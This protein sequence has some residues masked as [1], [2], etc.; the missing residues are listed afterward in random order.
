MKTTTSIPHKDAYITREVKGYI[1][2]TLITSG[3][4]FFIF[5]MIYL[6][7]KQQKHLKE[8]YD[9]MMRK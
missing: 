9:R 3:L 5:L 1:D 4:M 6:R 2:N 8:E 7:K